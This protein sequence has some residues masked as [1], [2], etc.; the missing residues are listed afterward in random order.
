MCQMAAGNPA[1]VA[2]ALQQAGAV[3]EK[4]WPSAADRRR[5][6]ARRLL[7]SRDWVP[8]VPPRELEG[9]G[10]ASQQP[11][12]PPDTPLVANLRAALERH[13]PDISPE[14]LYYAALVSF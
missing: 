4:L 9:E 3:L 10:G 13:C 12:P 5:H 1:G 11:A 8:Y 14:D 2:R 6:E 7:A